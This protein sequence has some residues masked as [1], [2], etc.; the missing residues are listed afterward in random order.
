MEDVTREARAMARLPTRGGE[1]VCLSHRDE[2]GTTHVVLVTG[3]VRGGDD[4][5]VRVHSECLTGD[6]FGSVR[7]D[8]GP[9]LDEALRL[10]QAE[11]RGVI[12][13]LRGHEGRGIGIEQKLRAYGLQD[14]GL[15]TV[16]ANLHLGLPVDDRDYATAA[17]ALG[18]LGVRSVRLLTNNPDK[19]D[20][21][22]RAGITVTTRVP[23]LVP[24]HPEAERYLATKRERMGHD[25]PSETAMNHRRT[26]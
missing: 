18:D 4:V 17:Q 1:F 7:C 13:Y 21:L 15:D 25:L 2:T 19:V 12:V 26:G 5:L 22:E 16:D 20:S 6:V 11:G 14:Q 10:V 24:V 23:L 8:C 9:Q 3:E